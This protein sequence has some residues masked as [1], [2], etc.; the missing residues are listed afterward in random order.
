MSG[1]H[2]SVTVQDN[3]CKICGDGIEN[4][5]NID[6]VVCS[7]GLERSL[8]AKTDKGIAPGELPLTQANQT[9]H[10]DHEQYV[11]ES[12]IVYVIQDGETEYVVRWNGYYT[13]RP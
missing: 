11:V 9:L 2:E 3:I 1:P 6:R 10:N 8:N 12:I 13:E 4:H 7:P 5:I